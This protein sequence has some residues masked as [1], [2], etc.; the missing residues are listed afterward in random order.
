MRV[1]EDWGAVKFQFGEQNVVTAPRVEGPFSDVLRIN[2][3]AGSFDPGSAAK[4]LAPA[5]GAQFTVVPAGVGAE[6]GDV[7]ILSYALRLSENFDFVRG[8]KL[9][10]LYGGIPRSGGQIP[11]GTDGF[12]TRIVWQSGG[13]GALYAY[14]PT[15]LTW[16]TLFGKGRWKFRPGKWI[17]IAQQVRLNTPGENNGSIAVWIDRELSFKVCG[18]RFRDVPALRLNGVFFS[19]FFGGNDRTW[20]TPN[21]VHID[22]ADF[23]LFIPRTPKQSG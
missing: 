21:N 18:V 22:F 11:N 10:G 1:N 9:P 20:A 2:Y 7:A 12:S 23:K 14:L 8:G 17:E 5:G 3:P 16:G 13:D 4:G 19:T 15:S 6:M